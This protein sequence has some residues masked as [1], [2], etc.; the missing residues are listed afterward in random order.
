VAE[1][2]RHAAVDRAWLRGERCDNSPLNDHFYSRSDSSFKEAQAMYFTHHFAH[3]ETLNRARS[4]LAHLGIQP[5]QIQANLTGT[6]RI[7]VTVPPDQVGEIRMLINAVEL[8]DPDG[9]PSFWELAK[10]SKTDPGV[11]EEA[12]V[13]EPA[14]TT[15]SAIGWHPPD[16]SELDDPELSAIREARG[17]RLWL[18]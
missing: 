18:S 14:K 9:F 4:W 3:R 1:L 6:P 2:R 15:R 16:R 12:G 13:P 8:T 11:P 5:H 17:Q 7:A 10:P